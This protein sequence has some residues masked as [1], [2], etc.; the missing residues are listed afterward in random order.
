MVIM[1]LQVVLTFIVGQFKKIRILVL[2][3]V[4]SASYRNFVDNWSETYHLFFLFFIESPA[5][6]YSIFT[7]DTENLVVFFSKPVEFIFSPGIKN[8]T[9]YSKLKECEISSSSLDFFS[10]S[11]Y[12]PPWIKSQQGFHSRCIDNNNKNY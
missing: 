2:V 10:V 11:T 6:Y 3:R 12:T 5:T 8:K 9:E 1:C 7:S 4:L